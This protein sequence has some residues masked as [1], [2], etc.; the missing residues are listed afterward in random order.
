MTEYPRMLFQKGG[1]YAIVNSEE[2]EQQM[3]SGWSRDPNPEHFQH[4]S[5]HHTTQVP[6]NSPDKLQ[7]TH[8]QQSNGNQQQTTL[9]VDAIV[10]RATEAVMAKLR[11]EGFLKRGPGRPPGSGR[12]P[13]EE[14]QNG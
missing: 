11:D 7:Q 13:D 3:G 6:I 14:S 5:P 10:R 2:E 1:G 9:D 8:G 12:Q 4:Q